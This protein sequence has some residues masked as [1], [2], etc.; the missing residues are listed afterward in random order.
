MTQL[1]FPGMID[2]HVHLREPGATHKEDILSGTAAALAGGVIAV[3]DMPNNT[4][5]ITRPDLLAA[6]QALFAHKAVADYGLFAGSDGSDLEGVLAMAGD[7]VGLKLYLDET[8]GDLRNDEP[9]MLAAL[10]ERWPGPG[11]IT[12]HAESASIAKALELAARFHQRLHVAHVPDPDDLLVIDAA[13]QRG[14][15][16]TCEVTPHHLFLSSEAVAR[17]GALAI[18]K[19][20]LV[21]PARR[22][23][24]WQRLSLVDIIASDHAPHTL[25][26]K[27]SCVPPPGVP[28]L[29][30]TVPLLLAAVEQGRLQYERML[31][32]VH[33]APLRVYGL[34]APQDSRVLLD[35]SEGM[36]TLPGRGYH[37]RCQ[38]SPF[39]GCVAMGRVSSVRVRGQMVWKDGELLVTPG[40]GL[41]LRRVGQ[42]AGPLKD[43]SL[44]G[45]GRMS[46]GEQTDDGE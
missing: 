18:I 15:R 19:P 37:T 41:P 4:P 17:L 22:E 11:P 2:A 7:T 30:T 24:F 46:K 33:D 35:L 31:E 27:A 16:V 8:F 40:S 1:S 28:G 26:E 12:V 29:E 32:L 9:A 10:F 3:L 42:A 39:E 44:G 45:T 43:N 38:W 21:S 14:V 13:R 20:P 23:L 25:S 6:K 5:P 34:A 36:Y